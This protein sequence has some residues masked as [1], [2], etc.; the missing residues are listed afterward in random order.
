MPPLP[1]LEESNALD[2]GDES[3]EPMFT[4]MLEDIPDGSQ[5]HPDINR[6]DTHYKILDCI[7][8]RQSEWNGALKAT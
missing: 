3:D 6:S 5:S 2:S 1:S 4:E 8:Q 7:K